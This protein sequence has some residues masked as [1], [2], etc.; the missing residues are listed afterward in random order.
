[1]DENGTR[2]IRYHVDPQ[3]LTDMQAERQF[4]KHFTH[5]KVN[6]LWKVIDMIT[7]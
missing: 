5:E 2:N 4:Y 7:E 1:M 3:T 6:H